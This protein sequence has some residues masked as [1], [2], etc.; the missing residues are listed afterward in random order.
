MVRPNWY[1]KRFKYPELLF[2]FKVH[3]LSISS[4]KMIEKMNQR[5]TILRLEKLV[6]LLTDITSRALPRYKINPKSPKPH[7]MI[8]N[9]QKE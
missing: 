4:L 2:I 1:N 3:Q 8:K 7:P 9:S 6:G 5:T